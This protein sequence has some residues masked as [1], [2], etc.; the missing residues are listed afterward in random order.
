MSG[1]K[2]STTTRVFAKL[3]DI[4]TVLILAAIVPYP[5]GPFA[6]FAYSLFCDGFSGRSL[7]KRFFKLQFVRIKNERSA[8]P[9]DS[10]IRNIPV[11]VATFFSLIPVWGWFILALVGIPLMIMEIYLMST[12][13]TGHRLGDVMA[14][15]EVIRFKP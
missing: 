7:G 11:G 10:L 15:T 4:F 3:I 12:V 2:T 8:T 1:T 6:G 5:A 9:R 14:D 13:K